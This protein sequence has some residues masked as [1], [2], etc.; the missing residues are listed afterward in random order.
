MTLRLQRVVTGA[1]R[2]A[3][4]EGTFGKGEPKGE[5]WGVN[6]SLEGVLFSWRGLLGS[7]SKANSVCESVCVLVNGCMC[8]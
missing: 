2:R 8:G 6:R 4:G 5:G 1:G 7:S 3:R